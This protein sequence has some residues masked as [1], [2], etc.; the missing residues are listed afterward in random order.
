MFYP[1]IQKALVFTA[2]GEPFEIKERPVPKPGPGQVVVKILATALNP[3]DEVIRAK[4]YIAIT[5][6]PAIIGNDAAGTVEA[7]GDGVDN[8]K[9]GDRV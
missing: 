1:E 2:P 5:Q 3:F 6:Y 4:G 7:L 9:I 8:F